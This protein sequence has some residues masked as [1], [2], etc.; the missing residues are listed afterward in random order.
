MMFA[1]L[2]EVD[3]TEK[4]DKKLL[5]ITQPK[6]SRGRK[7]VEQKRSVKQQQS[8][9]SSVKSKP[10]TKS[11]RPARQQDREDALIELVNRQSD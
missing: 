2:V 6:Q 11:S 1:K 8:Q 10:K 4:N 7:P 5:A 3:K 9:P